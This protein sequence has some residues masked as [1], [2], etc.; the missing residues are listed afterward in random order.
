M[1]MPD[2]GDGDQL[3]IKDSKGV[4][5]GKYS[6]ENISKV[7]QAAKAIGVDPYEA[8]SIALQESGFGKTASK[9]TEQSSTRRNRAGIGNVTTQL[10]D[11]EL[12]YLNGLAGKGLDMGALKMAYILKMKNA[13]AK[14]HGF[15][16]SDAL[17]LQGY[18]GWAKKYTKAMNGGSD[19]ILGVNI[20]DGLDL[21]QNPI[22]GARLVQLREDMKKNKDIQGLLD[23]PYTAPKKGRAPAPASTML[24]QSEWQN[25]L[26]KM[27]MAGNPNALAYAQ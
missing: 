14:N 18:Q 3:F 20:G 2:P 11:K 7:I 17:R 5:S 13:D 21:T 8:L 26:A 22:T 16:S 24:P 6:K 23:S 12:E 27:G 19:K 10:S 15:D 9:T 25:A 1:P 4:K